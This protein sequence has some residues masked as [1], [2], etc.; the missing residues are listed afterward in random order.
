ME[1]LV[2]RNKRN[3]EKNEKFSF[4]FVHVMQDTLNDSSESSGATEDS[5]I[6]QQVKLYK[7][8]WLVL[9]IFSWFS[10]TNSLNW[11]TFAPIANTVIEEYSVSIRL[12]SFLHKL[13]KCL[14]LTFEVLRLVHLLLIC[15]Q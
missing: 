15:Y 3:F 9:F 14:L 13:L 5:V 6:I 12:I 8:R 11:I 10:L 7:K 2:E 1:E 4:F